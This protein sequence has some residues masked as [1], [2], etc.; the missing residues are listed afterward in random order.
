M[1]SKPEV[2]P[3]G[4]IELPS[5]HYPLRCNTCNKKLG[6]MSMG[7][8]GIRHHTAPVIVCPH[9]LE[10]VNMDDLPAELNSVISEFLADG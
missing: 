6:I 4:N 3:P 8:F 1:A 5:E 10:D 9:C 2:E 7:Y